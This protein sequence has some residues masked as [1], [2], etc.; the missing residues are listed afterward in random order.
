[1]SKLFDAV[2]KTGTYMSNGTEKSRW[3]TVGAVMDDG[4]GGQYMFLD[5]TFNPAGV[6]RKDG[7][8]SVMVSF[9]APKPHGQTQA[10]QPKETPPPE[11]SEE[12][13]F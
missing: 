7:S 6:P 13:P 11:P 4:K 9:F 10:E 3:K 5:A 2:V 8:E 12:I 1:M